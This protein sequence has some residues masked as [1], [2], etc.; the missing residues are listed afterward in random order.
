[1]SVDLI[2]DAAHPVAEAG[3]IIMEAMGYPLYS[4]S[5]TICAATA[6]LEPGMI[7]MTEGLQALVLDSPAGLVRIT[8]R[9]V[10][11]RVKSITTQGEPAYVAEQGMGVEV[12]FYGRV[13]FDLVWSGAYYALNMAA[14]HVFALRPEV[15]VALAAFADVFVRAA[16]PGLR[17]DHPTLG[18]VGPCPSSTSWGRC[19]PGRT[20]RPNP[21][22]R[23]TS[24][25]G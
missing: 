13:E 12:P 2:V 1:M 8:A 3:Y 14:D 24:I 9:N 11:G 18:D 17:Q 19:G 22:R 4:G 10:D 7:P 6:L 5:N 23:R 21:V 25:R 16:R 20:A 15:Q